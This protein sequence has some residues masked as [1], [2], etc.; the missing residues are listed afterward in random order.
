M[1]RYKPGREATAKLK[2]ADYLREKL[3]LI[4]DRYYD[5]GPDREFEK[6]IEQA[7]GWLD[8]RASK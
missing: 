2:E 4:V 1:I 7:A 5:F 3:R 6:L 8:R